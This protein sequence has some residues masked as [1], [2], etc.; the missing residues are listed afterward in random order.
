MTDFYNRICGPLM[1]RFY[2]WTGGTEVYP[3][4]AAFHDELA[5]FFF[6]TSKLAELKVMASSSNGKIDDNEWIS[7]QDALCALI[8]CCVHSTRDE[9][10]LK[11]TDRII[12]TSLLVGCR[13]KLEPPLPADYIG[14][15]LDYAAISLPSRG[16]DSTP[17]RVAEMAHLL[18]DQIKQRDDSYLRKKMAALKSVADLARVEL[19]GGVVCEDRVG[20][21]SWSNQNWY[22]I[23]WGDVVGANIERVRFTGSRDNGTILPELKGPGFAEDERG[24]EVVLRLKKGQMD[25][26][27]RNELFRRFAMWRCD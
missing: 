15:C 21:S 7:T 18:R 24:L 3:G 16:E 25:R 10:I 2:R 4:F 1:A 19:A 17:A 27:K 20:F 23:D 22:N 11:K 6:P 13:S 5:V 14:N 12:S 8:S 26:L 9:E